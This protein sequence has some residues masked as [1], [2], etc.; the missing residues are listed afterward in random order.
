MCVHKRESNRKMSQ[1]HDKINKERAAE[2]RGVT[3]GIGKVLREALADAGLIRRREIK[4][5]S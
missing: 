3:T 5:A 4:Q 2:R 1:A